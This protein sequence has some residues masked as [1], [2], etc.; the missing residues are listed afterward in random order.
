MA[1]Q[2]IAFRNKENTEGNLKQL[3]QLRAQDVPLLNS[4]LKRKTTWTEWSIQNEV[5]EMMAHSILRKLLLG[6]EQKFFSVIADETSD[7]TGVE[8]LVV[9]VRSV[10][11]TFD[12]TENLIGMHSMEKF[13]ASAIHATISD[14]LKRCNLSV[15]NKRGQAYD[16]AAT[17]A[18]DLNG[19]AAKF[20][21]EQPRALFVHCQAHRLNLAIQDAMSSA[22]CCNH[23]LSLMSN[24]FVIHQSV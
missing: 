16:A 11:K 15:A 22:S 23:F 4:W 6:L 12:V 8:Q 10:N 1:R 14:I 9:V 20:L 3:L 21:S 18:G 19:V 17:I 2:G 7:L 13:D 24:L 5:L